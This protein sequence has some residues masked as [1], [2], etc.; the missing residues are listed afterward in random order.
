[1]WLPPKQYW[2]PTEQALPS[3]S[4]GGQTCTVALLQVPFVGSPPAMP[5]LGLQVGPPWVGQTMA[6]HR[7]AGGAPC[8]GR[9]LKKQ[10][11]QPA[12]WNCWRNIASGAASFTYTSQWQPRLSG[13]LTLQGSPAAGLQLR[14][15][16][17]A[18]A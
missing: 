10:R 6:G 9:A 15:L 3:A 14:A 13:T 5:E 12:C 16:S 17:R 2:L 8:P 11:S 18:V 7:V 4:P 1:L